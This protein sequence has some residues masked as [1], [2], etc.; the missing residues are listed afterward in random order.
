MEFS[1][2]IPAFLP[3]LITA[4][5]CSGTATIENCMNEIT[6]TKATSVSIG[7]VDLFFYNDDVQKR[8]D[9]YQRIE[10][11][12][13][14][15]ITGASRSGRKV[16]AAVANYS[17]SLYSWSDINSFESASGISSDI[18]DDDPLLPVM[19]GVTHINAGKDY[20]VNL[21][22]TPLMSEIVVR[23]LRCDFSQRSYHDDVLSDIKVYLVNVCTRSNLFGGPEGLSP[24][25]IN[26]GRL[27][28][29]KL[30]SMKKPQLFCAKIEGKVGSSAIKPDTKL[31]CYPN[32]SKE[33]TMGTPFTRL[34]IEGRLNGRL[35]YYPVN[36]NGNRPVE[37]GTRYVMDILLTRTG[38]DDPDSALESGAAVVSVDVEKWKE[39]E[40]Q[41]VRF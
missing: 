6:V 1:T 14:A 20:T 33:E 13:S 29:L 27:D 35:Y 15:S 38:C 16:L 19:S 11:P 12:V 10:N 2:H 40:K 8:L 36:V 21:S 3:F 28:S 39:K 32:C 9:A 23:S 24:D 26:L 5:S 30:K 31:Y 7:S 22:L 4:I 25:Y 18:D 37:R 34:V 17:D 41:H